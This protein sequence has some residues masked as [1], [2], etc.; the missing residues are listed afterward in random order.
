MFS[1][2]TIRTHDQS[3]TDVE[4]LAVTTQ[5]ISKKRTHLSTHETIK[6]TV[7]RMYYK[8]KFL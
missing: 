2:D 4:N 3:C 5:T 7:V 6:S 8:F 1:Y